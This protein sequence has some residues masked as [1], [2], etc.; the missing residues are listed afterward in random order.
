MVQRIMSPL[1]SQFLGFFKYI[2]YIPVYSQT[3]I[4]TDQYLALRFIPTIYYSFLDCLRQAE[5]QKSRDY[6]CAMNGGETGRRRTA[7]QERRD[8]AITSNANA[9]TNGDITRRE[10]LELSWKVR[11]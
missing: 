10:F 1:P 2:P 6:F 11:H 9:F 3:H 5:N 4:N 8:A 7:E